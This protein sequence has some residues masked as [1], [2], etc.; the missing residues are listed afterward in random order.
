MVFTVT[1]RKVDSPN[2]GSNCNPTLP[3]DNHDER[4]ISPKALSP[5]KLIFMSEHMHD[6]EKS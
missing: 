1:N 4:L 6:K 2:M 3:K 5:Y